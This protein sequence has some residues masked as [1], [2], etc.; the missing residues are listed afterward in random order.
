MRLSACIRG[1]PLPRDN[2]I[3]II[4]YILFSLLI[5]IVIIYSLVGII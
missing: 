1:G 5:Y 4:Y 3:D 2:I